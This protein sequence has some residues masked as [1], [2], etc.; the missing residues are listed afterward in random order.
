MQF[1]NDDDNNKKGSGDTCAKIVQPGQLPP[2]EVLIVEQLKLQGWEKT[3]CSAVLR[4]DSSRPGGGASPSA[5]SSPALGGW[6][7]WRRGRAWEAKLQ[8]AGAEKTRRAVHTNKH[9]KPLCLPAQ[10]AGRWG[11]PTWNGTPMPSASAR[12]RRRCEEIAAIAAN[13]WLTWLETLGFFFFVVV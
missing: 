3:W 5:R 4:F 7:T 8:P 12:H 13:M 9:S 10:L 6:R 2:A 11:A 1:W